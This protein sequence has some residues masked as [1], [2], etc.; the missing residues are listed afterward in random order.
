MLEINSCNY[1]TYYK[2]LETLGFELFDQFG[3]VQKISKV[4]QKNL[5]TTLLEY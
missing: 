3:Q 2:I 1:D 4:A 5:K